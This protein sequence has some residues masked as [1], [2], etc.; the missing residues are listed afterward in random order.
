MY[1][2]MREEARDHARVRNAYFDQV[3]V[4]YIFRKRCRSLVFQSLPLQIFVVKFPYVET[5]AS[6]LPSFVRFVSKMLQSYLYP[7]DYSLVFLVDCI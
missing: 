5:Y 7:V 1:A 2:D 4:L 6:V 3:C